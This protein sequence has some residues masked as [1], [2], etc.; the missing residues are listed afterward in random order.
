MIVADSASVCLPSVI[1]GDLPNGCTFFNSGG[2][3]LVF[4]SRV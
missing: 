2:A 3:R 1:T 4:A